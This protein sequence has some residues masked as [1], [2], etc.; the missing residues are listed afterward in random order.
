MDMKDSLKFLMKDTNLNF[1]EKEATFCYGMCKMTVDKEH[2]KNAEY[3][4]LQ[5]VEFLE[6]I[7]RAAHQKFRHT[8]M[9]DEPLA[10]QV[11]FV[12]DDIIPVLLETERK[13]VDI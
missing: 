3:F 7:G 13:P 10:K 12:L 6:M 1:I 8:T 2:E 11:E 9:R 5:F 4:R